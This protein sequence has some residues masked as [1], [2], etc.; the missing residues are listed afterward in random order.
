ME[1]KVIGPFLDMLE[2]YLMPQTEED[3]DLIF[4]FDGAPH[5]LVALFAKA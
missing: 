5:N 3:S 4:Q 1:N 2:N